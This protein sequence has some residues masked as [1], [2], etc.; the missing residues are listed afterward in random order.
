MSVCFVEQLRRFSA[1]WV[2]ERYHS[3]SGCWDTGSSKWPF[4]IFQKFLILK[5][6]LEMAKK[7]LMIS[8]SRF[9]VVKSCEKSIFMI[10]YDDPPRPI[11]CSNTPKILIFGQKFYG[12]QPTNFFYFR[13]KFFHDLIID[14]SIQ[15]HHIS[16]ARPVGALG[17]QKKS[18]FG[19]F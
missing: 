1:Q 12:S 8:K 2:S 18:I 6:F 9:N 5:T 16:A 13:S 7:R 4:F 17:R 19:P 10:F 11:T 14:I 15:I 3:T